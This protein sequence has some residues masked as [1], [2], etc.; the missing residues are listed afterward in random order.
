LGKIDFSKWVDEVINTSYTNGI[1]VLLNTIDQSIIKEIE[2]NGVT[3]DEKVYITDKRLWH[4]M[5]DSKPALI[6]LTI[7]ELK[8]I[9]DIVNKPDMILLDKYDGRF[10]FIRNISEK[11]LIKLVFERNRKNSCLNYYTSSKIDPTGLDIKTK[12][13][14]LYNKKNI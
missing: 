3:L 5:R 6:K 8:S 1:S 13:K 7:D 2:L 9:Y 10:L 4:G 11:L 12:H 14:I